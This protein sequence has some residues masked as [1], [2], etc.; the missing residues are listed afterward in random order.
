MS[1]S[2]PDRDETGQSP[3][4]EGRVQNGRA[5]M[6]SPSPTQWSFIQEAIQYLQV[7]I[8]F[9]QH[10]FHLM[11]C[12]FSSCRELGEF[13]FCKSPLFLLLPSLRFPVLFIIP[14]L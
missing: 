14:E 1:S 10:S 2:T 6:I 5:E 7:I 13:D 12:Q 4:W 11:I 9:S 3:E 8:G